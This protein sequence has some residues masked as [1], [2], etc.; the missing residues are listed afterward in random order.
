MDAVVIVRTLALAPRRRQAV[1]PL[2]PVPVPVLT[3]ALVAAP[4][5]YWGRR[6]L[7]ARG[8]GRL[9]MVLPAWKRAIE[10]KLGPLGSVPLGPVLS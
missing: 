4:E 3:L 6:A 8:R 10:M 7:P 9:K 1:G 2:A 5:K